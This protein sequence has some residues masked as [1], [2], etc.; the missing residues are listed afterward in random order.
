MKERT[1]MQALVLYSDMTKKAQREF[2]N[3]NRVMFSHQTC[4]VSHKSAK[5]YNRKR[6]KEALAKALREA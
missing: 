2:R 1:K 5:D 3:R 4:S 6:E